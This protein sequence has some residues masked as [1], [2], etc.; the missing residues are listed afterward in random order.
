MT[1]FQAKKPVH[2]KGIFHFFN[3]DTRYRFKYP[4]LYQ[5]PAYQY[6][7]I[8][9]YRH[10]DSMGRVSNNQMDDRYLSPWDGHLAKLHVQATDA[11]YDAPGTT[12]WRRTYI[13]NVAPLNVR[14]ATWVIDF[15]DDPNSWKDWGWILLRF[16]PSSFAL[17][18]FVSCF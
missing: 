5:L 12:T 3:P 10:R 7:S 4:H 18:F 1:C 14:I 11:L 8:Q 2:L 13:R 15:S 9:S 6:D 17:T 16:I